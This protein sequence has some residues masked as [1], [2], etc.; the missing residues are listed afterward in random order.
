MDRD[1]ILSRALITCLDYVRNMVFYDSF[2]VENT[3]IKDI[4]LI[5][6]ANNFYTAAILNWSHLYG[7]TSEVLHF[8]NLIPEPDKYKEQLLD[9]LGIDHEKWCEYWDEIKDYRDK[10]V[11]HIDPELNVLIPDTEIASKSVCFFYN[12]LI[13]ELKQYPGYEIFPDNLNKY[14]LTRIKPYKKKVNTIITSIE[15]EVT[16]C[17]N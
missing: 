3:A 13:Q 2:A 1:Q 14:A 10:R 15:K 12:A 11:A 7:S 17:I 4:M 8:R 5:F 6:I 9:E 16:P